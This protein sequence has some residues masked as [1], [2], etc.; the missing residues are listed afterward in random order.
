[1]KYYTDLSILN[2][3]FYL[4]RNMK[5]FP[6]IQSICNAYRY[7]RYSHSYQFVLVNAFP[8][9]VA[10]GVIY[11]LY[12]DNEVKY[13][14]YIEMGIAITK[15]VCDE[16]DGAYTVKRVIRNSKGQEAT[17]DYTPKGVCSGS[18]TMAEAAYCFNSQNKKITK[19]ALKKNINNSKF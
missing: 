9:N 15:N 2:D 1:M 6:V 14:T 3:S 5:D 19:S 8:E 4:L 10:P 18:L 16:D 17:K 13:Q 11:L 12:K 7:L